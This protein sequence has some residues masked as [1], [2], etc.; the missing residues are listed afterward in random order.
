MTKIKALYINEMIKTS[1]KISILVMAAIMLFGTIG[2]GALMKI[3]EKSMEQVDYRMDDQEWMREEMKRTIND[4]EDEAENLQTRLEGIDKEADPAAYEET[5]EMIASNQDNLDINELALDQGIMLMFS[6]NYLTDTLYETVSLKEQ[7]RQL[8]KQDDTDSKEEATR[9]Q[10][11]L[12]KYQ[13]LI[14]DKNFSTFIELKKEAAAADSYMSESDKQI[15]SERLDL[16]FKIDPTGGIENNNNSYMIQETLNIFST[17]KRSLA[18]GLDYSNSGSPIPLTPSRQSD[19]ENELAVLIYQTENDLDVSSAGGSLAS[20][21]LDG[22]ASFG[23]TMIVLMILILAG[24]A[25]SQEIAT[26]SIKSLIIAPVKRWKIFLAK[27]LSL[28]T[29]GALALIVHYLI[30]LVSYGLLFGFDTMPPYV[31][32]ISGQ[33]DSMSPALYLF[34]EQ[35]IRFIE[36]IVFMSFA[37][38]LSV[39][40]RNTAASV[41][42]SMAAYFGTSIAK[43]ILYFLP[44]AEWIKFMPFDHLNLTT[45]FFPYAAQEMYGM[46]NNNETSL[47]FSLVYI[48]V[49][50]ACMLYTALD[51]FNRRDIK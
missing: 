43:Q 21:A 1:K 44:A 39:L 18:D 12:E 46:V 26:G 16:W 51:S 6:N 42:I 35:G 25:V 3:Q 10:E 48:A 45:K 24:G 15:E 38:M 50:L 19:L 5:L 9:L 11:L 13:Q 4:L 27:L 36:V 23:I 28:L 33:A 32:A 31:Y 8:E 2:F 40:T 14:I 37:L 34:A 7:I 29:V 22:M 49:A 47:L 17:T 41:G 20:T 30:T